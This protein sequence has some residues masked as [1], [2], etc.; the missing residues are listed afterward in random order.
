MKNM[1]EY[2]LPS[3]M[4]KMTDK[5]IRHHLKIADKGSGKDH[6]GK[7]PDG[8]YASFDYCFN[9]FHSFPNKK[10]LADPKN[11]QTSCLHLAFFLASWGMLRGSTFLLQKSIRYYRPLIEYISKTD[12]YLWKIDADNYSPENIKALV[13][14]QSEIKEKLRGNQPEENNKASEILTT[15]IMMGVFG[16]VPAFDTYFKK[17][18]G[19]KKFEESMGKVSSFY[20]SHKYLIDSEVEKRMTFDFDGHGID[21]KTERKYTR[22]KIIDMIFFARGS[23]MADEENKAKKLGEQKLKT[24]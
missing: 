9:Y 24:A 16:N 4:K 17:G 22:A 5:R 23:E 7:H 12:D 21:S 14:C 6:L 10:D 15:K 19:W 2:N 13:K 11:I 3:R 8:R 18:S 1:N 20:K